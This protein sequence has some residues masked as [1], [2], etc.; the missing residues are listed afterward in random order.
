[1]T[2]HK[3]SFVLTFYIWTVYDTILKTR[4]NK[5]HT[6][7]VC[8]ML[9]GL[10]IC[11]SQGS[12][13]ATVHRICIPH[14]AAALSGRV[15]LKPAPHFLIAVQ[16]SFHLCATDHVV[17]VLRWRNADLITATL[18]LRCKGGTAMCQDVGHHGIFCCS[19]CLCRWLLQV[20]ECVL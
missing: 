17:E 10:M 15:K 16:P 1:M 8:Y 14:T 6:F 3:N 11:F 2:I 19:L 9:S 12:H 18:K 5:F 7:V 4:Q 20:R 13:F